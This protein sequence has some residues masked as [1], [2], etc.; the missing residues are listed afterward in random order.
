M[1]VKALNVIIDAIIV[2]VLGWAVVY[3]GICFTTNDTPTLNVWQWQMETR[4]FLFIWGILALVI[5]VGCEME[6]KKGKTECS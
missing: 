3:A 4:M 2:F 1:F 5:V 6:E